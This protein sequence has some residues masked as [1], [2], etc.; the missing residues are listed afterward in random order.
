MW[1]THTQPTKTPK[2]FPVGAAG[3]GQTFFRGH[4]T[5]NFFKPP[6]TRVASAVLEQINTTL[7][8]RIK[9]V[10]TQIKF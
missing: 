1:R 10:E 4:P 3:L 9:E 7:D 6:T 2:P 8:E 5:L